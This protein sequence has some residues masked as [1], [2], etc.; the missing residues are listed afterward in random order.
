MRT[1]V[2]ILTIVIV[3]LMVRE[4]K[5]QHYIDRNGTYLTSVPNPYYTRN[6]GMMRGAT[7]AHIVADGGREATAQETADWQA[8]QDAAALAA[9]E[10]AIDAEAARI[11]NK[12]ELLKLAENRFIE[13]IMAYNASNPDSPIE[14]TDGFLEINEAI[15]NSSLND[16]QQLKVGV[17]LRNYWDVV[18]FHGGKF[19][20]VQYHPEVVE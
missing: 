9:A 12:P 18:L 13:A 14:L 5:S 10:A 16:V 3:A 17:K 15:E 4:A 19:G 1:I 8:A 11:A 7:W 20:D 2:A 6:G